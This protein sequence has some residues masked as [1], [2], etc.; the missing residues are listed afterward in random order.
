MSAWR[1]GNV[2]FYTKAPSS[3]QAKTSVEEPF[4]ILMRKLY[5]LL[6]ARDLSWKSPP[7]E[8]GAEDWAMRKVCSSTRAQGGARV[9]WQYRS[10]SPGRAPS[11][12]PLSQ[13]P[14]PAGW[15]LYWSFCWLLFRVICILGLAS[16]LGYSSWQFYFLVLGFCC[17]FF[18]F[19]YLF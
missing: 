12:L 1:K 4:R 18:K 2:F 5:G 8:E 9:P 6:A 14:T 7:A 13:P 10:A 16:C 17:D 19:V 15:V 3:C 11:S